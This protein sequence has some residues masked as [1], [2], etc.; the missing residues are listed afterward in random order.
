M[1]GAVRGELVDDECRVGRLVV[2]PDLQG[3]GIGRALLS[4][5]EA[6][7]TPGSDSGSARS[8]RWLIGPNP[9][10]ISGKRVPGRGIRGCGR[11]PR[12]GWRRWRV[13]PPCRRSA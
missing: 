10:W 3:R 5:V 13:R 7:F 9:R 12:T 1:V 8:A 6:R 2:A 11:R 4:A